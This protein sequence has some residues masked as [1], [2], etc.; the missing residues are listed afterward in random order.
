[1]ANMIMT[2]AAEAAAIAAKKMA[3]KKGKTPAQQECIDFLFDFGTSK[4]CGCLNKNKIMTMTKYNEY[5]QQKCNGLD[6]KN[7]ALAKIGLD[8]SQVQEIPPIV[9][10]SYVYDDDCLIRVDNTTAVSSQFSITWIFFSSTQ[11]YT[12][13]FVF[14]TTSDN[15]W[16]YTNDFFYTDVTCFR[17]QRELKEKIEVT[18][19]KGCLSKEKVDKNHYVVDTLELIVPGASYRF[20][21]RNSETVEQSI[22]AAKAMVREKKYL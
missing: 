19:G 14:D 5:V 3:L 9:L 20:S 22:Q 16:E 17:T 12:Y 6:L 1:M 18:P 13:Q 15:T 4:G 7:R 11:M 21:L 8:P 10:S 2:A